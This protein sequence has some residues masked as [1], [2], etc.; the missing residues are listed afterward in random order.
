LAQAQG[1]GPF[2]GLAYFFGNGRPAHAFGDFGA[3]DFF[4]DGESVHK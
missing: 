2:L 4:G 3:D 1:G